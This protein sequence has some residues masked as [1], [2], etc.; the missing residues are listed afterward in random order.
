MYVVLSAFDCSCEDRGNYEA[1]HTHG[2]E[3]GPRSNNA[4][5]DGDAENDDKYLAAIAATFDTDDACD[6]DNDRSVSM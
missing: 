6:S 2:A 4:D 1:H 3:C 5:V